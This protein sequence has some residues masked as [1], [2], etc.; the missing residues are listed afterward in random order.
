MISKHPRHT[1][2]PNERVLVIRCN[3]HCINNFLPYYAYANSEESGKLHSYSS[4]TWSIIKFH[5]LDVLLL[6]INDV[7]TWSPGFNMC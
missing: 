3:I 5:T 6:L 1:F 7:K 2:F 4:S